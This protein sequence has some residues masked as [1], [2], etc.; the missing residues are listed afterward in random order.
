[1][2]ALGVSGQRG[3]AGESSSFKWYMCA[4]VNKAAVC[5]CGGAY[6]GRAQ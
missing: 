1:M 4:G 5:V 3:H 2:S 6:V